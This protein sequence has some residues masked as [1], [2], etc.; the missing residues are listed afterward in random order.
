MSTYTELLDKTFIPPEEGKEVLS[1][2]QMRLFV[3]LQ[4]REKFLNESERKVYKYLS[5]RVSI[6]SSKVEKVQCRLVKIDKD[7]LDA[8]CNSL[9]LLYRLRAMG[10]DKEQ[11]GQAEA[12]VFGGMSIL[13]GLKRDA[14]VTEK[15][16]RK[17]WAQLKRYLNNDN[18]RY[19]YGRLKSK[20]SFAHGPGFT[21]EEEQLFEKAST[22]M[23]TVKKAYVELAAL[24]YPTEREK[25]ML[26]SLGRHIDRNF[27][28]YYNFA[29]T[30][31]VSEDLKELEKKDE[32]T[33]LEQIQLYSIR[34]YLNHNHWYNYA[35]I[36][37]G[38]ELKMVEAALKNGRIPTNKRSKE[39]KAYAKYEAMKASFVE[40]SSAPYITRSQS[41]WL[42][43]CAATFTEMA[44]HL[45]CEAD[46]WTLMI[47]KDKK[48][49]RDFT[50]SRYSLDQLEEDVIDSVM[51]LKVQRL[52]W[53]DNDLFTYDEMSH[54]AYLAT[55]PGEL[56]REQSEALKYL[57]DKENMIRMNILLLSSS[58]SL[59]VSDDDRLKNYRRNLVEIKTCYYSALPT[60]QNHDIFIGDVRDR[61]IPEFSQLDWEARCSVLQDR[62]V[63][64]ITIEN[65]AKNGGQ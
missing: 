62:N 37:D 34:D 46:D 64:S 41:D 15:E 65:S 2:E 63:L 36:I 21:E 58:T 26:A 44:G 1:E 55:L 17:K 12:T 27:F 25:E 4:S 31:T 16:N 56:T 11:L 32:L 23:E 57:T 61:D 45:Y 6:I 7:V 8:Y 19:D 5:E 29:E 39:G 54:K 47:E 48:Q 35:P 42:D 9:S 53:K 3:L 18:R 28:K 22:I 24:T 49:K 30:G 10:M 59:T 40:F 52:D 13:S 14:V 38:E 20:Y 43:E 50:T 33:P 60:E 51:R